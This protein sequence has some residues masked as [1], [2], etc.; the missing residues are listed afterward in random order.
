MHGVLAFLRR[1]LGSSFVGDV[2]VVNWLELVGVWL[3]RGVFGYFRCVLEAFASCSNSWMLVSVC[4]VPQADD[5]VFSASS[6]EQ[7]VARTYK[8]RK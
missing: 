8:A 7:L 3:E 4:C 5:V 1:L 6:F 2:T